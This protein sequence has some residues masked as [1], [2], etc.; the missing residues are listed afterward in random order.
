MCFE[1][2]QEMLPVFLEPGVEEVFVRR[3]RQSLVQ[4][5]LS[6]GVSFADRT[7]L[8]VRQQAGTA[9]RGAGVLLM[10][11]CVYKEAVRLD[12]ALLHFLT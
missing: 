3:A 11:S 5:F 12:L 2:G 6:P 7:L 8:T 1:C 9:P 4:A 10:Y